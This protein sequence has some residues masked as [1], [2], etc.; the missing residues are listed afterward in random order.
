[1]LNLRNALRLDAVASGALGL[2]VLVL[3]DPV[4]SELGFPVPFSLAMA[5]VLLGWAAFVAFVSVN[6]HRGLVRE[7]VALNVVYVVASIV[8]AVADWADLTGL[9]VAFVLVQAAAVA[10]FTVAQYAGLRA[11][12]PAADRDLVTA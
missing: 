5:G 9:G 7:V 3:F 11:E 10:G 8:F 6:Q 4:E 2:L 1:M 12:A